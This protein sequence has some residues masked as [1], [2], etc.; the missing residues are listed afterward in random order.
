MS[1]EV[2]LPI[3]IEQQAN[4]SPDKTFVQEVNGAAHTYEQ[5]HA[6]SRRWSDAFAAAGVQRGEFVA[7]MLPIGMTS[8]CCWIGLSW[9]G[10]AEVPINTQF[11]SQTLL[12]PLQN[13][14]VRVLV[15]DEQFVGRLA[16]LEIG[17]AHV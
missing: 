8:Y 7:S 14:Q 6:A 1:I 5:F 13:C 2:P 17:R 4:S 12:Y 11:V 16:A 3:K 10:A 9:L 15:I